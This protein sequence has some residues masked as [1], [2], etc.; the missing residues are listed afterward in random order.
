[1]GTPGERHTGGGGEERSV[2]K[3][4]LIAVSSAPSG[5]APPLYRWPISTIRTVV[6]L[7]GASPIA[8]FTSASDRV[9]KGS[10]AVFTENPSTPNTQ[11]THTH[12][13][14]LVGVTDEAAKPRPSIQHAGTT[15]EWTCAIVGE[16]AGR[17]DADGPR[18]VHCKAMGSRHASFS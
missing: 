18:D 14:T 5:T 2:A 13:H 3:V 12:T 16:T 15:G 4:H 17:G 9:R 7:G 11:T 6:V 10:P 8:A 1:M